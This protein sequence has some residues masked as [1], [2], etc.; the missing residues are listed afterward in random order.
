M[1]APAPGAQ[2]TTQAGFLQDITHELKAPLAAITEA[3]RL[4]NEQVLGATTPAKKR[5]FVY[6]W[7]I[8]KACTN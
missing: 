6:C 8:P 3:S 7:K 1:D 4:L 2:R 5:S